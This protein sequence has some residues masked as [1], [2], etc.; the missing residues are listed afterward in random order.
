MWQ[1]GTILEQGYQDDHEDLKLQDK[2]GI[3]NRLNPRMGLNM[4][5]HGSRWQMRFEPTELR[6]ITKQNQG[7]WG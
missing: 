5:E 1:I 2:M 3:Y 6:D 4:M 7:N